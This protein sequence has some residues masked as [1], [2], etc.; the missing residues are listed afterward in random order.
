MDKGNKENHCLVP[1]QRIQQRNYKCPCGKS[2]LSYPALFT[3]IKQKHEGKVL[4]AVFR[5]LGKSRS[6]SNKVRSVPK[7]LWFLN[8]PAK[9]SR[10]IKFIVAKVT[11]KTKIKIIGGNC[12]PCAKICKSTMRGKPSLLLGGTQWNLFSK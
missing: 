12:K 2:Y 3:H 8:Y 9:L 6:P 10:W 11:A 1:W 4:F 7:A 5:H